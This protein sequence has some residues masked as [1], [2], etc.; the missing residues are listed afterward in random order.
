MPTHYISN[1]KEVTIANTW[2]E[3]SRKELLNLC[4]IIHKEQE[5]YIALLRVFRVLSGWGFI[6]IMRQKAA[7]L[8]PFLELCKWVYEENTFTKNILIGYKGFYLP[9]DKM[10]NV[11]VGEFHFAEDAYKK[12][13][14]TKEDKYLNELCAIICR[15][16]LP[17]YDKKLNPD[18]DLRR[19]FKPGELA[20]FTKIT[21]KWPM[22]VKTAILLYFDGCRQMLY[23]QFEELFEG[24]SGSEDMQLGM[25]G[26]IRGLAGGKYG[27]FDQV[28]QMYIGNVLMELLLL[29]RENEK[30]E[31][32]MRRPHP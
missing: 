12:Y 15:T 31:A 3:L 27:S 14:D 19:P 7:D 28:E 26:I 16:A 18:N 1:K 6:K 29:K 25:Y 4:K 24:E 11:K 32:E 17:I 5:E 13:I 30:M 20:Y 2:N 23:S 8:L 22:N 9:E 10:V 21:S